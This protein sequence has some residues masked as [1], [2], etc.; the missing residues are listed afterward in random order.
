MLLLKCLLYVLFIHNNRVTYTILAFPSKKQFFQEKDSTACPNCKT[1]KE[2]T[3]SDRLHIDW[4]KLKILEELGLDESKLPK[5]ATKMDF[6]ELLM[7]DNNEVKEEEHESTGE[8]VI[9]FAN[10]GN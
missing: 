8:K 7:E 4:I 9:I 2:L 6:P 10:K 3:N 5:T 1:T